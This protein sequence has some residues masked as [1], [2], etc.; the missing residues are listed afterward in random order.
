MNEGQWT[1]ALTD[2]MCEG[3]YAYMG[4][5]FADTFFHW[6]EMTASLPA[7]QHVNANDPFQGLEQMLNDLG[8]LLGKVT[9]CLARGLR[10]FLGDSGVGG[11]MSEPIRF[12]APEFKAP[13]LDYFFADERLKAT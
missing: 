3:A 11:T 2:E 7:M 1:P 5:R 4:K 8:G 6:A 13:K 9:E 12:D 10:A